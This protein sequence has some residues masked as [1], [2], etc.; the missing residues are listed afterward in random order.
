[1]DQC[2]VDV[3]GLP[4]SLGDPVTLFG[5]TPDQLE[6]LAAQAGTITYEL[7]CLVTARV[8]RIIREEG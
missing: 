7:L 6:A 4:V 3:T 1:M 8:P 5:D 2:M